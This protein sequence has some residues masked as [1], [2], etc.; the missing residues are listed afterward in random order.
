MSSTLTWN[1]SGMGSKTGTTA[2]AYLTDLKALFDSKNSDANFLWTVAGS[3]LVTSPLYVNLKRKDAS[4]GRIL[5]VIWT[6]TPAG[7]N[8]AILEGSP[9]T[10]NV[11]ACY[12]PNGNVDTASNLAAS[13]GTIMG[14]DTGVIKA[15]SF[16]NFGTTY[17]TNVA[18]YYADCSAGIFFGTGNPASAAQY[19]NAAGAFLVDAADNAY[20]AVLNFSGSSTALNSFGTSI[21]PWQTSDITAGG[22]SSNSYVRTN[23][24]SAD[25]LYFFAFSPSGNW[26]AASV[27]S[28]D[29]MTDVS[30]AKAWFAAPILLGQTKGEGMVL[31]LRQICYGPGSQGPFQPYFNS[32]PTVVARQFLAQTAGNAGVPWLTNFKV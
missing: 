18:H 27:S 30:N 14:D 4:V 6:S 24:G 23:Y 28:T 10:A 25:R 31:K 1:F 9:S 19:G 7:N 20:D 13:S 17:A 2:A 21:M 12:F 16:G 22:N 29:I 32:G 26:P 11:F 8:S 5:I 15:T 3:E